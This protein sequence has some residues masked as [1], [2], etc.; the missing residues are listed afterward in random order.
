VTVL[1]RGDV[2]ALSRTVNLVA[3]RVVQEALTNILKHSAASTVRV[4]LTYR[5]QILAIEVLD[6]GPAR[7][8]TTTNS[9]IGLLGM[10]ERVVSVRGRLET[11]PSSAGGY[12]VHAQLPIPETVPT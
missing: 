11:G 4:V 8:L 5:E 1:I 3:Y 7:R 12:R 9:G 2:R 10:R 6:N